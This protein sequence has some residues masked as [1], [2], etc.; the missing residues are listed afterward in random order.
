MP[1]VGRSSDAER[2][3]KCTNANQWCVLVTR[4][5]RPT[6]PAAYRLEIT[7]AQP[8][9]RNRPWLLGL[10]TPNGGWLG[11]RDK[12]CVRAMLC[13]PRK[14]R[15]PVTCRPIANWSSTTGLWKCELKC[16]K[17]TGLG[18]LV[19]C[20]GAYMRIKPQL[21]V[22][23]PRHAT[24]RLSSGLPTPA[25]APPERPLASTAAVCDAGRRVHAGVAGACAS[26][27]TTPQIFHVCAAAT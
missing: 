1:T 20:K 12:R 3:C 14:V 9:C 13:N 5:E 11:G 19:A 4:C 18:T 25:P 8:T 23:Q 24:S 15:V 17:V 6:K 27:L 10:W 7:S 21:H 2:T 16:V 26:P 22:C